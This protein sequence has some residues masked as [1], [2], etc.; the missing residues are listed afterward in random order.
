M[1]IS[2]KEERRGV[3]RVPTANRADGLGECSALSR[4]VCMRACAG[5]VRFDGLSHVGA[6]DTRFSG[7][8]CDWESA[9]VTCPRLLVNT[10]SRCIVAFMLSSRRLPHR[11]TA[12]TAPEEW[13]RYAE[14][15]SIMLH[16]AVLGDGHWHLGACYQIALFHSCFSGANQSLLHAVV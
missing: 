6:Q 9:R 7:F 2:G 11:A 3:G 5:V 13:K 15:L 4:C 14:D 16:R 8:F 1:R 12:F 10:R